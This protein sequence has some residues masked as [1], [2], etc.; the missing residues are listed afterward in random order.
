M[1]NW[2]KNI[3]KVS[4]KIMKDIEE[5]Y[6]ENG[7]FSFNK[8]IPMPKTLILPEGTITHEAIAY[9][10]LKMNQKDKNKLMSECCL[11]ENNYYGNLWLKISKYTDGYTLD[12][13]EKK[14]AEYKLGSECEELGINTLEELGNT[15]INNIKNYKS[16]TWYDWS[17]ANWGTKWDSCRFEH[18]D[19]T[20]IFETAW[21]CPE[22]LLEELS[23][24]YPNECIEVMYAD[25][26]LGSNCGSFTLED[27][28]IIA[29]SL[30]YVD[31]ANEVWDYS[32]SSK[33]YAAQ[34]NFH[35]IVDD[36]TD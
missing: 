19:V 5:K 16:T 22:P 3:V 14:H 18:D 15:Y 17:I 9:A 11:I 34:D 23:R 32:I 8:I 31:F 20:L 27:G 30:G 12:Q 13:L 6:F 26:D 21:S 4:N 33:E 1:P 10:L 28:N 25:E 7:K 2:V 29:D 36:M 35:D 24:K